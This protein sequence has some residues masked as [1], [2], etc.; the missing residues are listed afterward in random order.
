MDVT[1][2]RSDQVATD[3]IADARVRGA[4]GAK[5][6]SK[7]DATS[8][9]VATNSVGAG[10]SPDQI[11]LSSDA[12]AVREGVE[13][14]KSAPDVRAERV[15]ALRGQIKDGSYKVDSKAIAEKMIRSSLEDDILARHE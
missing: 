6:T 13:A 9:H 2:L 7:A 14:A 15:A 3:K 12:I 4:G 10:E 5:K 11:K 1:K 8:D